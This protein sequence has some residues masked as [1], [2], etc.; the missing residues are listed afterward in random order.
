MFCFHPLFSRLFL[1]SGA[2]I[3][4]ML[5]LIASIQ[6]QKPVERRPFELIPPE[7][8]ASD[9]IGDRRIGRET[10]KPHALYNVNRTVQTAD[11]ESMAREYLGVRSGLLM[12]SDPELDDLELRMIREHAGG[13]TV[14]FNQQYMGLPVYGATISININGKS[15]VTFVMNGYQPNLA[16][17]DI[18]PGIDQLTARQLAINHIGATGNFHLDQARLLV[19]QNLQGQY[20]AWEIKTGAQTPF[21]EWETLVDA[22]TGTVLRCEDK[23]VY[24]R[25][26]GECEGECEGEGEGE[27]ECE[28]EGEDTPPAPTPIPVNGTGVAFDP[29]PLSSSGQPYGGQYSDGGDGNNASLAAE[30]Q[31]VTLLDIDLTAGTHSLVGPYAEIRDF[32]GPFRGLF[33]QA[34]S[35]FNFN[36]QQNG[37]EAVNTYYFLDKSMRYINDTLLCPLSPTQYVGGVRFDP[38]ALNGADNSYYSGA[39]GRLAFGEGGVDDAEDADVILHELGHALH[40]WLTGGNLSQVNGLSEGSGDYW[41]QSYSRSL[42]QWI[43]SDTEYDWVFNWDGHNPFWGGRRTD[44]TAT[45]PGGLIGQIHTDGQ[46]WATCMMQIWNAIG[47]TRT[48]KIFLD[49]LAMTNGTTN[50]QD[51]AIAVRQAGINLGYT[52]TELNVITS[53]FTGCG[54]ILP[55]FPVVLDLFTAER[56]NA[57]HVALNWETASESNSR[58]FHIERK[59][60]DEESFSDVGFVASFGTTNDRQP[61][62]FM[63]RNT[64]GGF[65]QYRL[66]QEDS[67]GTVHYS[68]IRIVAGTQDG[69]LEVSV[70]PVPAKDRLVVAIFATEEGPLQL[71]MRDLT[72]RLVLETEATTTAGA[73]NLPLALPA[74]LAAGHYL[75]E[76]TSPKTVTRVRFVKE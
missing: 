28:G 19:Y 38:H 41:A 61:Y 55:P 76:V 56:R 10:G 65:S 74:G 48:D 68:E 58:G 72:G 21:G 47:R 4:V 46:I 39:F 17:T 26:K 34:S 15:Q 36:R 71:R 18:R 51:A 62:F 11:W 29:D 67:D 66:R 1:R 13:A 45:Y 40:D 20:L 27:E 64:S 43:P 5:L 73:N 57:T 31:T 25:K 53:I 59:L 2:L 37:F 63:D 12:L 50:Q 70:S 30:V 22:K 3:A 54:Y 14:R 9:V 42:N 32:E 7:I 23:L 6:A 44:Y 8:E 60:E 52:I 24:H 75:L 16:L 33:A 69:A 35:N 49:G